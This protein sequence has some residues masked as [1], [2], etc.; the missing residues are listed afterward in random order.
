MSVCS[1]ISVSGTLSCH[2]TLSKTPCYYN[3]GARDLDPLEKGDSVR[4]KPWQFGK[5]EWQKGVV[6][7]RLDERSYE[8]EL[9]K[10]VLRRNR[11]HL[12]RTYESAPAA[13]DTRDELRNE[14]QP[15]DL[16]SE[17]HEL[18]SHTMPEAPSQG[19]TE[20]HP[21]A[22]P[23][24]APELTRSQGVRRVSKHLEECVLA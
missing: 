22:A 3:R 8:V 10:G 18:P 9:P 21:P 6:K 1:R 23:V 13:A 20:V 16:V 17:T 4:V 5:K 12:R 2:F 19:A 11:I 14:P 24:E 7:K 15:Q